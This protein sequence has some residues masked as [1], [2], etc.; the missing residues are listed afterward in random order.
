[1]FAS[2]RAGPVSGQPGPRCC[3]HQRRRTGSGLRSRPPS[4]RR[5][6][7]SRG[8]GSARRPGRTSTSPVV[9]RRHVLPPP[10]SVSRVSIVR[11]PATSGERRRGC[12]RSTQEPPAADHRRVGEV[13][14]REATVHADVDGHDPDARRGP[15]ASRPRAGCRPARRRPARR[16]PRRPG[17]NTPGMDMLARTARQPRPVPVH[18]G[19]VAR[20]VGRHAE[21][22]EPEVLDVD[23]AG[24]VSQPLGHR[25]PAASAAIG[26]VMS[27]GLRPVDHA[28]RS[29]A[30]DPL[31][32][33]P[34]GPPPRPRASRRWCRRRRRSGC[35]APPS[36]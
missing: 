17:G 19:D 27:T 16:R 32:R 7:R 2:T 34:R 20:Q 11:M 21:V 26:M 8:S 31:D 28:L 12:S 36:P 15:G 24:G 10:S 6:C 30:A 13:A 23:V 33:P 22:V 29:I 14:G 18:L 35:R 5:S 3:S 1:M 4:A 9:R 25:R